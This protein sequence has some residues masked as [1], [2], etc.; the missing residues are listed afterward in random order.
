MYA[1]ADIYKDVVNEMFQCESGTSCDDVGLCCSVYT[2]LTFTQV[3][4][5]SLIINYCNLS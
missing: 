2:D 5:F 3:F 4:L 1:T